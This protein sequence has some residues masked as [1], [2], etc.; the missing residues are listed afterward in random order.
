MQRLPDG[1]DGYPTA[2]GI[3]VVSLAQLG[4]VFSP[5]A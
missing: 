3:D 1:P 5:S 2:E 4:R